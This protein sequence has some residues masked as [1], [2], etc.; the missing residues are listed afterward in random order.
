MATG[1]EKV[2]LVGGGRTYE[3]TLDEIVAYA[4]GKLVLPPATLTTPGVMKVQ[5][6]PGALP[7]DA[8]AAQI[9][10]GFNFFLQGAVESGQM[11]PSSD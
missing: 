7:A 10:A 9:V 8:T 11:E 4:G 2:Y 3:M 5:T 6:N 1:K